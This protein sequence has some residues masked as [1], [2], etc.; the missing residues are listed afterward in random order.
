[1][2]DEEPVEFFPKSLAKIL[3][4]LLPSAAMPLDVTITD[5][6]NMGFRVVFSV[7]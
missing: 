7:I 2:E 1:M 6:D 3:A 4:L 5:E